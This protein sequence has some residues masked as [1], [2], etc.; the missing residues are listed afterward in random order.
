MDVF[1]EVFDSSAPALMTVSEASR[2]LRIGRQ[3]AYDLA[4]E[5]LASNGESGL[6]VLRLGRKNLRV[7]TWAL[8]E[9]V[10]TGRVVQLCANRTQVGDVD[11]L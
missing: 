1:D 4:N 9:L 2:V 11:G 8:A 5:Y 3:L 10:E 6:P 7:P